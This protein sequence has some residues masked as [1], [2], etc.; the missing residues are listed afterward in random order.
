[1]K[2]MQ[3]T[4]PRKSSLKAQHWIFAAGL[5]LMPALTLAHPGHTHEIT[6]NA[7]YTGL[8]HPFTGL[9]HLL[10]M[11]TVGLWVALT[12]TNRTQQAGTLL[13]FLVAMLAGCVLSLQGVR[14]PAVEPLIL[15]SLLTFGLLAASAIRLPAWIALSIT[16]FFAVFHGFAHGHEIPTQTQVLSYVGGFLLGTLALLLAGTILGTAL[17]PHAKWIIRTCGA[18]VAAYGLTLLGLT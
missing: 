10:A 3:T 1:M 7:F 18:A 5:A 8:I 13:A 14:L 17:R 4:P 6:H 16:S 15:L 12:M 2:Q 11:L 9:D